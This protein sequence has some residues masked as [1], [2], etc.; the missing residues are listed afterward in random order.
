M[1]IQDL[2]GKSICILGY[3]KEG[4]AMVAALETYAPGC[5]I[6]IADRETKIPAWLAGRQETRYKMQTG[7]KYLENLNRF[8]VII[9]SPG[10]PPTKIKDAG[11]KMQ[12][13][14]TQI[15]FDTIAN[16]GA[17]VIG[18]TGSKGKSTTASIITYI[19]K[20]QELRIKNHVYLI[21]NIGEPAIAHLEDGKKGTIFVMEMSSYQ[22]MDL[23]ISPHIAVITSFF[24][25]HLDYHETIDAYLDAK[26]NITRF[27]EGDDIVFFCADS[28]GAAEI[29][30]EGSGRKIPF[31]ASDAPVKIEETHLLGAHNLSNIA[32]AFAVARELGVDDIS[33]IEA[34]KSFHGLPHRL[35]S[36]GIHHGL[37]WIDDAISTAPESTIAALDALGDRVHTI[38][39]GGQDRGND[40]TEL[41]KRIADTKIKHVILFP[42]SGPRI[43]KAIE[44]A[45]A[46]VEFFE[47]DSM[48][49]AVLCARSKNQELRIKNPSIV[50]LST[51]SPSYGMFKNFEEKGK[52]FAE[53]IGCL[54]KKNVSC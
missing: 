34:I 1:K 38:I 7:E 47:T 21:G 42:G 54:D 53:C 40:F 20:N 33:A 12:T 39:L 26:K 10:I 15:F 18:V 49:E 11:Y 17:T 44:E 52:M 27:Q 4:Q 31:S 23:K 3:G 19:L 16:S 22:L 32:A 35:Q 14:P 13:T 48:E 46:K 45:G 51:A 8:D 6:T 28:H 5:E 9:K 37:E 36:L 29:A 43:R 2:S 30:K 24:P 50:L 41:G 25:E